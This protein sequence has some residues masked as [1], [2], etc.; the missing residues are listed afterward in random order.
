MSG[1][2][3]HGPLF[4][5][6]V[7]I[8]PVD[9]LAV[10]QAEILYLISPCRKPDGGD[11][12]VPA[13][14]EVVDAALG[15][16][17][18]GTEGLLVY[19]V[20]RTGLG[21]PLRDIHRGEGSEHAGDSVQL[22]FSRDG[23]L[24][25][26]GQPH[27]AGGRGVVPRQAG[28]APQP[29]AKLP[30]LMARDG[31]RRLGQIGDP[32]IVAQVGP[33]PQVVGAV[34]Q[35]A[36]GVPVDGQTALVRL[37]DDRLTPPVAEDIVGGQGLA[38]DGLVHQGEAGQRLYRLL[39]VGAPAQQPR[40]QTAGVDCPGPFLR[41]VPIDR[42]PR[43][44]E[45]RPHQTGGIHPVHQNGLPKAQHRH[46]GTAILAGDGPLAMESRG[47][48]APPGNADYPVGGQV[49][50]L[51]VS[52]A[53]KVTAVLRLPGKAA[54]SKVHMKYLLFFLILVQCSCPEGRGTDR[55]RELFCPADLQIFLGVSWTVQPPRS[56]AEHLLAPAASEDKMLIVIPIPDQKKSGLPLLHGETRWMLFISLLP[57]PLGYFHRLCCPN[58]E[59]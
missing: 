27:E 36:D 49:P 7:L 31:L 14:R 10:P 28:A 43:V 34:G 47:T 38:L 4:L 18:A 55:D 22:V 1:G 5:Y 50:E 12:P 35:H 51:I 9:V 11:A 20:V 17:D 26:K 45:Q 52:P 23:K 42:V 8:P 39:H 29:L 24:L 48:G 3:G 44:V 21:Q 46:A 6:G 30:D 40:R 41:P 19:A 54:A 57:V 53:Q 25:H 56:Q 2:G 13:G 15:A 58:L 59:S 33:V 32:H 16:H 37:N